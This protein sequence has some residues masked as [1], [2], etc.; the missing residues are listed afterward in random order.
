MRALCASFFVALLV[1]PLA[2]GL[3]RAA[4]YEE[5]GTLERGGVDAALAARGLALDPE[6][7]GKVVGFIHVVNLDV[8]QPSDGRLLEW[9]NHF[10]RTSREH[11]VRRESLLLPGMTYDSALVDETMRNLRNRNTY[12]T[13]DPTWSSIVAIVPTMAAAPGTVDIL[14]VTRDTWSLRFNS[15]YNYQPGYLI[16]FSSSLSENNLFGW[17][18]LVALAF[19]MDQGNLEFGPTYLDPN[20]LG[21]RLRLTAAFYEIWARKI[22]EIAAGPREGFASLQRLEYP[23]YALS[24][25]WGGFVDGSYTTSV[26]RKISGSSTTQAAVLRRFSPDLGQCVTPGGPY[27]P[28]QT[29]TAE[30][31]YRSR[32]GS[33]TSGLTR[34]FPRSWLIQRV[35][36]GNEV[37]FP[38]S[39]QIYAPVSP[40]PISASPSEP[41][42]SMSN[43][44]PS[45]RAI[46][47]TA[48]STLTISVRTCG[49]VLR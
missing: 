9:F 27:D 47:P 48:I 21:T 17:R 20:V 33:F 38:T 14:I 34:S 2:P 15:D 5:L 45:P 25:H 29:L 10:H 16:N 44:M 12:N 46:G 22:G 37:S 4:G 42:T 24:Q 35:T 28:S 7:Q 23:F 3:A 49:S 8:F 43:T 18:K 32:A 30:C 40:R 36:V 41:L 6:P 13:N 31:A 39:P 11:H 1:L 26:A 19:I